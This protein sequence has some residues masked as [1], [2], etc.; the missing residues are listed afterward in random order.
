MSI[1]CRRPNTKIILPAATEETPSVDRI[2]ATMLAVR[3]SK[4]KEVLLYGGAYS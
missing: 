2:S 1:D 4:I 3:D